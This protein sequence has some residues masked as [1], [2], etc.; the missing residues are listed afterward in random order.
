MAVWGRNEGRF[1]AALRRFVDVDRGVVLVSDRSAWLE[2]VCPLCGAQPQQRCG[3]WRRARGSHAHWA[4]VCGLHACRG[5]RERA[6]RKCGA[7]SG[8]PCQSQ[9]GRK[10][11]RVHAARSAP[12]R[13]EL[14]LTGEIWAELVRRGASSARVPF[15]GQAGRGGRTGR[16]ELLRLDPAAR[17]LV[18]VELWSSRDELCLA[19]EAPVWGRFGTFIGQPLITGEIRWIAEERVVEIAAT[20]G[21]RRFEE[22]L[23]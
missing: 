9:T 11:A 16:I 21:G 20:R 10:T 12:G 14:L 22:R 15:S 5:W 3:W 19:L 7:W 13:D 23:S 2:V 18:Q 8:Y 17:A 4:P 6:C 1:G